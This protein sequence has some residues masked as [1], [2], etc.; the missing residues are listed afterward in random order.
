MHECECLPGGI[1]QE[2]KDAVMGVFARGE[3]IWG[4]P[5]LTMRGLHDGHQVCH[6]ALQLQDEGLL[7]GVD[8]EAG[9]HKVRVTPLGMARYG[10]IT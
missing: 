10:E 9:P 5:A 6:V 7:V 3:A 1:T 4:H 2:R 8:R